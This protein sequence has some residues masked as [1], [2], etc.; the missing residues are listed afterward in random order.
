MGHALPACLPASCIYGV[1][2]GG[3]GSN[4]GYIYNYTYVRKRVL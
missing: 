2:G 4:L 3:S 1:G